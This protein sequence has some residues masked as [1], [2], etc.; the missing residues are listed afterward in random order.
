[1]PTPPKCTLAIRTSGILLLLLLTD[2]GFS[3]AR[4]VH[5][6]AAAA[7]SAAATLLL[8]LP[9]ASLEPSEARSWLI[10]ELNE[11]INVTRVR[12]ALGTRTNATMCEHLYYTSL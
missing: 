2:P 4:G 1:M 8:L 7:A 10:G 12:S 9:A 6:R 11:V 5:L 3:R